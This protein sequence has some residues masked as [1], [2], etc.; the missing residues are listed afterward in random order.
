MSIIKDVSIFSNQQRK[1]DLANAINRLDRNS[2]KV[3]DIISNSSEDSLS[4]VEMS[5]ECHNMLCFLVDDILFNNQKRLI[6]FEQYRDRT[7]DEKLKEA[8]SKSIIELRELINDYL[9]MSSQLKTGQI[10][11]F[12]KHE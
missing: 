5:H 1:V 6:G 10:K 11:I 2:K 12:S 7:D 3:F 4:K 8:Y 9:L